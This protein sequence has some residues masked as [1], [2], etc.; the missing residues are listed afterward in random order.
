VTLAEVQCKTDP[1]S[2]SP[3]FAVNFL[4][5]QRMKMLEDK[6]LDLILI[7]DSLLDTLSQ[8]QRQCRRHCLGKLCEDCKCAITVE[9]L[10]EQMH[11]TQVNLRRVKVL[12]KRAQSTAQLVC[13]FS[14]WMFQKLI[15]LQLSDFLEY[16]NSRIAL[17]N[18]KSLNVLVEETRDEN[19]KTRSLTVSA[20]STTC[21]SV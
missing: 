21:I 2:S 5:R 7:F 4:D 3:D 9:E 10:K 11:D 1:H 19:I 15:F 8:L 6:I 16:Q 14:V 17:L 12:H 20:V 18:D 13:Q